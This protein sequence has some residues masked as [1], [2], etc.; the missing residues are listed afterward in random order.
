MIQL[1]L[2][3]D[4]LKRGKRG[5]VIEAEPNR[6]ALAFLA[7]PTLWPSH[8]A[9]LVG[10]PRSGRSTIAAIVCQQ[11]GIRVVDDADQADEVML[12]HDWNATRE[13]GEPLLLIA[14]EAPP[15]W[16]ITLPDLR[17]RLSAAGIARILP[18]D[19]A[20]TETLLAQGLSEAGAAFAPDVPRYLAARLPRCYQ[21]IEA[22]IAA[23]NAASL[24][25]GRKISLLRARQLL[26]ERQLLAG[27]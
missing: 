5:A 14:S 9:L 10:P 19:E 18:P 26:E 17:S 11:S 22:M 3:I 7:R 21:D 25:S 20:L 12:F 8:C 16:S 27:E 6:E 15:L 13:A 24:S 23:L 1:P 4:W 2:P